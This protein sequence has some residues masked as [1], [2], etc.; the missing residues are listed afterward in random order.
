MPGGLPVGGWAWAVL[1]LTD[2]FSGQILFGIGGR[3]LRVHDP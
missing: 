3:V 2:T 1:E